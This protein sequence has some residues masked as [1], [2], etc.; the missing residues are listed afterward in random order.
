MRYGKN[1]WISA[2]VAA[3][4][5]VLANKAAANDIALFQTFFDTDV[6]VAGVGNMRNVGS[7]TIT[8]G[9]VSGTVTKAY[10]YWHGPTNS[11]DLNA[12]ASVLVN[13]QP[14]VGTNIG[15]SNDNCWGYSNSQAYR[16]DVTSLVSSTGNG[17]YSLT[18]F[19]L[20]SV[21]TNGASLIVFFDDGNPGN[22]RD[23]VLF[24]GNDS[25]IDNSFDAPGWN[26]TLSGINYTSGTAAMQ[27]HVGDGQLWSD[28]P[29]I[30][31]ALTLA[32]EPQIFDGTSVPPGTDTMYGLWDIKTF[33]VTSFLN[34]GPNTLSLTT[35]V[36]G[37]CL[38]LVVAAVDLPAGAAPGRQISLTPASALNCTGKQH[39]VTAKM[40]DDTGAPVV[41][42]TVTF[43]ITSGPNAGK[44]GSAATDSN[45]EAAF[46][47]ADTALVAG[48]DVIEACFTTDN[49]TTQCATAEKT[50]EVCNQPPDVSK[51]APTVSCI[52]PPNHKL[53]DVGIVGV[54]DPD[55][56]AINIT[57]TGVTSDEPTATAK[58][59][60]GITHA[61]DATGVGTGAA[62]LRAE[63]SGQGDGRVY[64]ISFIADDGKAGNTPGTV[65]VRVPRDVRGKT[66]NAVDSGQNYDA[67]Q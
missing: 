14:V 4:L 16:A 60:G 39:T 56:D 27:L 50:W 46:T 25:N 20:G 61:P 65:Q 30:L 40:I 35:G 45:G 29:L 54:T 5:L 23:V 3:I 19:G 66:C 64:G 7:G 8:L 44:A 34:P 26:V 12:N 18:G 51:A 6:A 55:G 62:G 33:D 2:A 41:G 37:D 63:R 49:N 57:I 36:A 15:L 32:A 67:T 24:E 48:T 10:L 47:Y 11:S 43:E 58:G 53:V 42:E 31:N 59:A 38:S 52:W 21:N 1:I 17:A 28:A 9:G 22:N 13:G